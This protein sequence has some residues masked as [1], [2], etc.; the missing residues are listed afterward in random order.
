MG[1]KINSNRSFAE[2]SEENKSLKDL[3]IEREDKIKM[4]LPDIE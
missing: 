4:D 2:K 1:G 3:G